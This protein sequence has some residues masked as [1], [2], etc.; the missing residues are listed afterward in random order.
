MTREAKNIRLFQSFL[1]K[2]T[3]DIPKDERKDWAVIIGYSSYLLQASLFKDSAVAGKASGYG[4]KIDGKWY[5]KYEDTS[6]Y[7]RIVAV[8]SPLPL[9]FEV[10]GSRS[11]EI[12]NESLESITQ[13]A[14]DSGALDAI[15]IES[16][17]NLPK[18]N[19]R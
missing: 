5:S 16:I 11:P 12:R 8:W 17:T 7:Q 13:K 2:F 9:I 14:I 3:R 10:A 15:K 1:R 4:A 19:T 6:A 18:E